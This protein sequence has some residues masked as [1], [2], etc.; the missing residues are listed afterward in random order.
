MDRHACC[1]ITWRNA[2]LT[3]RFCY[4]FFRISYLI[5]SIEHNFVFFCDNYSVAASQL[6]TLGCPELI[7]RSRQE[8]EQIAIRLGNDREYLRSMR[9]KVWKARV[10]SPLF[11]CKQYATGLENLFTRM[12]VR[13]AHGDIPDHIVTNK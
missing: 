8:Y 1:N 2:R 4:Y 9:H 11:D 10:E 3:V 7:A 5:E 6:N 12:W 13:H